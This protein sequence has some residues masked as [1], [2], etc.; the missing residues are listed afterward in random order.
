[1][2]P[3][4]VQVLTALLP[5]KVVQMLWHWRALAAAGWGPGALRE[6]L[7]LLLLA[8]VVTPLREL[9]LLAGVLAPLGG[10][11][12]LLGAVAPPREL[13]LLLRSDAKVRHAACMPLVR[14]PTQCLRHLPEAM[15]Q[16]Q[17]R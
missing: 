5:L 17:L 10:L 15:T 11:L 12:L 6:L 7:L 2:L 4:P 13:L 16:R 3:L 1:M 14:P 9:L 8:G